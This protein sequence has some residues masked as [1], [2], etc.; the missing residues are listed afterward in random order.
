M[1]DPHPIERMT[2]KTEIKSSPAEVDGEL[3][4]GGSPRKGMLISNSDSI[5]T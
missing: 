2:E 3:E 1:L 4:S 5:D